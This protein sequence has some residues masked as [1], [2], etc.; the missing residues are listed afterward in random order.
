MTS[1]WRRAWTDA[2]DALEVD[3]ERV[4][5][6][7]A[8]D[9]RARDLPLATPWS[10]PEGLG[11]LPLDLRPRADAI[12]NRQLAAAQALALAMVANRRQSEMAARIEAGDEPR[13]P[14][15]LDCAI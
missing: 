12:L 2:L 6:L 9:H 11:E 10:P 3:V 8:E 5:A 7:L 15:Y 4:E 13:R 1:G 14:A